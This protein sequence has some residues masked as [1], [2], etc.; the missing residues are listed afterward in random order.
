M[1]LAKGQYVRIC[2]LNAPKEC[3]TGTFSLS[4]IT[5]CSLPTGHLLIDE[6]S[7]TVDTLGVLLYFFLV[8]FFIITY[9]KTT[10]LAIF[11]VLTAV[12]MRIRVLEGTIPC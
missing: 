7:G 6:L 12:L 1:C 4:F 2:E 3:L 9:F 5:T 8:F 11:E 10:W